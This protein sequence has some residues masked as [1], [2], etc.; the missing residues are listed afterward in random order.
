M[1]RIQWVKE[2]WW[3]C[4][5][6][7]LPSLKDCCSISL[8][9]LPP[10]NQ[11]PTMHTA[12]MSIVRDHVSF[13]SCFSRQISF[14]MSHLWETKYKRCRAPQLHWEEIKIRM[15]TRVSNHWASVSCALLN[16]EEL[17]MSYSV[18]HGP[19]SRHTEDVCYKQLMTEHWN[20]WIE[21]IAW[22]L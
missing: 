17:A 4:L 12:G 20:H 15:G 3:K 14:W 21:W 1:L 11:L 8:H 22:D 5:L 6:P 10:I 13:S 2:Q 16:W 18:L 7:L 19:P 9:F